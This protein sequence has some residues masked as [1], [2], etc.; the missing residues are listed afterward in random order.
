MDKI[1]ILIFILFLCIL[2]YTNFN[3]Y[4]E[5]FLVDKN[6]I[7]IDKKCASEVIYSINTFHLYN[8]LDRI[9]RGIKN[10]ENINKHYINK[11]EDWSKFDKKILKWLCNG[12]ETKIPNNYKFLIKN[13]RLAKFKN[14][15]EMDFPHTNKSTIF[16][17]E[18]FVN[19]IVPY[20]NNNDLDMCIVDIGSV[21]IHEC[22]H[23]WQRRNPDFFFNL[24]KRWNFN[25][26]KQ[27]INSSHFKNKNRYN[28][29]GVYLNWCFYDKKS[30]NE[31][32]LLSPY[33]DDAKNIS[34][35]N[36]IGIEV[37]KLGST[38]IIPP[39]PT[40]KNLKELNE[41]QSFFGNVGN[42]NYH[43][44]ELAAELISIVIVNNMNVSKSKNK[45]SPAC[46]IYES[47]FKQYNE[48]YLFN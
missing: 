48:K 30:D 20:F 37:E 10:D 5:V 28:P 3:T 9:L 25:K 43:P 33:R 16:M 18:R 41:F 38:A 14:G 46:I 23:I 15:V 45:L 6:F 22:V 1:I 32:L 42:N 11:L 12:I 27:I 4:F 26:Y 47:V 35:V 34:H 13:I 7:L 24:Y 2:C 29:D 39:I 19:T 44:N 40:I 17:S 21:I 36:F 8:K 31:Y